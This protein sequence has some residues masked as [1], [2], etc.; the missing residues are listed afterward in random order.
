MAY[1]LAS[2][3]AQTA[4]STQVS[5]NAVEDAFMRAKKA[6]RAL[7]NIIRKG[8]DAVEIRNELQDGMKDFQSEL[9]EPL[10]CL[11]SQ[12]QANHGQIRWDEDPSYDWVPPLRD[13][14]AYEKIRE[15]LRR[16][17]VPVLAAA[18]AVDMLKERFIEMQGREIRLWQRYADMKKALEHGI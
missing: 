5:R 15:E 6:T 18:R 9:K 11:G 8:W 14:W 16:R 17:A 13:A 2:A 12:V 4:P 7:E 1:L 10:D 3:A